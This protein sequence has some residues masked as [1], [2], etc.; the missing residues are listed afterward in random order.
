MHNR[1]DRRS[2]ITTTGLAAAAT[3][4]SPGLLNAAED[5]STGTKKRSIKKGIMYGTV[6]VK[7]SVLEKFKA[8]KE[9]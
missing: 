1:I 8:V 4:L 3:A 6:G 7:G 2:F 9:A 5:P